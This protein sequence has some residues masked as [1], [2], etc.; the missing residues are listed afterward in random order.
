MILA[1]GLGTRLRPLSELRAKPAMP[2]RGIPVIAHTLTLLARHDVS[3]VIINLHHLPE[4]V[5]EAAER[6]RP[7]GLTLHYS[8]ES[9]PLGTGG[10]MRAVEDFLRES[11]PSLVLSGDML[12]DVDLSAAVAHH[13]ERGDRYTLLLLEGDSRQQAFGTIG[14]DRE[15]C[16]RRIGSRFDLGGETRAGLFIGVRIV[17]A[18]CL[19]DW[20]APH[21]FEDLTDW[22]A[23]ALRAGARDIRAHWLPRE[24]CVW[25]PVGTCSEYL[26]VNL[27][28]PRLPYRQEIERMNARP[29]QSPPE[30]ARVTGEESDVIVGAGARIEPGARL[31]R[32]VVWPHEQVPG[33]LQAHD[34]V[35]A[36]GRFHD[37][38][39][40]S[41]PRAAGA[42][43]AR[44]G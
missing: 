32:V 12:L 24:A 16:V 25:E 38:S 8:N 1:A 15:D 2:V 22:Q 20:P 33:S 31:Q 19:Q 10:A 43:P 29:G 44:A 5:R 17:A 28:P 6:Y 26:S 41:E 13:R 21:V 4:S 30:V 18:R 40:L 35:F 36:G 11:D 34:G 3:E 9:E 37:C 42:G 7:D 27:R 14:T 23:P 39:T